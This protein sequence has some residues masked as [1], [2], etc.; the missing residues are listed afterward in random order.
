MAITGLDCK[1]YRNS[2]TYATPTWAE[3]ENVRDLTLNLTKGEA[4]VSRR[5]TEWKLTKPT[6]K[7]GSVDFEMVWDTGD[8]DFTAIQTA[9]NDGTTIDMAFLDGEIGTTGSQG[10]RAEFEVISFTRSE[11]LEGGVMASVS[12]KPAS[13]ANAPAWMTVA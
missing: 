9:W 7:D 4:D 8:A 10:L 13:T 6:L 11:P 2:A 3:V 1:A 12:L 5:G